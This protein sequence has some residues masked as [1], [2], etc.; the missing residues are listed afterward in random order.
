MSNAILVE[1]VWNR[2][3]SEQRDGDERE[4]QRD[5]PHVNVA[6]QTELGSARGEHAM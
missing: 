4:L 2:G 6:V 3:D 5:P 1:D